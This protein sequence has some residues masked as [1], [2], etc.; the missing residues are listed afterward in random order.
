MFE[1]KSSATQE[2]FDNGFSLCSRIKTVSRYLK[3]LE[4]AEIVCS[5]DISKATGV[6][7][8]LLKSAFDDLLKM[9]ISNDYS[10]AKQFIR[11]HSSLN[12]LHL[13]YFSQVLNKLS[14]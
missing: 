5:I 13:D 12:S 2:G 9:I 3:E 1:G 7:V 14:N 10:M 4:M 11:T 8:V 6:E